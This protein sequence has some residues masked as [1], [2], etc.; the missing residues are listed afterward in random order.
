L[1]WVAECTLTGTAIVPKVIVP[2]QIERAP[3]IDP[4]CTRR[5]GRMVPSTTDAFAAG[6]RS[7]GGF[8]PFVTA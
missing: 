3:A 5:E 6:T 2:F 1:L 4:L 8:Q 7:Y